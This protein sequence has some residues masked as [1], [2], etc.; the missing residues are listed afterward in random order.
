MGRGSRFAAVSAVTVLGLLLSAASSSAT[1]H[2][3]KIREIS[4]GTNGFDDSYVEVQMYAPFQNFLSGGAQVLVCNSDCSPNPVTFSPFA[5]VAN[6]NS[7]DTVLFGDSGIDA[8]SKDFNVNLNL[9][10]I[11]AGGAVCYLSEPGFHDCLSWGNFSA[12]ST[13]TGTYGSVA[14]TGT[15]APALSSGMALRRSIAANCLTALDPADDTDNSSA[16]FSAATPNPRPNSVAPT[17]MP[18]TATVPTG[19]PSQPAGSTTAKKKKKKCRKRKK[20]SA[21]SGAPT[22]GGGAPAYSAKKKC[23]KK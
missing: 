7:Q 15:P 10:A 17:E 6:G 16:D 14:S 22:S 5:N 21:G 20:S 11:K 18:C 4:P 9:D 12:N 13:L 3:M 8:G 23:K 2:L 1:F 19:A